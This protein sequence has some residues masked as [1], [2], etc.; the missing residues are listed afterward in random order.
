MPNEHHPIASGPPKR[1][2]ELRRASFTDKAVLYHLASAMIAITLASVVLA[3]IAAIPTA[4]IG[5]ILLAVPVAAFFLLRWYYRLYFAKLECTLT[6]RT[7]HVGKG[8][9]YRTEKA[10]P[11]DRITD[12]SM[13]Q[14]PLLRYLD[15]EVMGVETA[16]QSGAT[17]GGALVKLVGIENSRDFR[18]AVLEQRDRVTDTTAP[19]DSPP[20][21]P[22]AAADTDEHTQLLRDIRNTLRDIDERLRR[23]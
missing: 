8:V 4:G 9:V 21:P 3:A 5:L 10:I 20:P 6:R 22:P 15:L 12:L 17:Q 23:D 1:P 13:S 19:R 18:A 7:L 14:G 2:D 11:L 16:G